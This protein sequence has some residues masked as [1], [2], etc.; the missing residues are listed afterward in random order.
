MYDDQSH[1]FL[2]PVLADMAATTD[3]SDRI[4]TLPTGIVA[5][6]IFIDTKNYYTLYFTFDLPNSN[7]S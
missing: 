7:F 1:S 3:D 2:A 6:F 5:F 4:R